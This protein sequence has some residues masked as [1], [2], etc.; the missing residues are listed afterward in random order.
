MKHK[1]SLLWVFVRYEIWNS[2]DTI[3]NMRISGKEGCA[4]LEKRQKLDFWWQRWT[5]W[6]NLNYSLPQNLLQPNPK[7]LTIYKPFIMWDSNSLIVYLY[8]IFC[9]HTWGHSYLLPNWLFLGLSNIILIRTSIQP[10][11]LPFFFQQRPKSFQ[12]SVA[13]PCSWY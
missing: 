3:T 13:F 8:L 2:S 7:I 1:R 11:F 4:E 5:L 12:N 9:D 6:P 10:I